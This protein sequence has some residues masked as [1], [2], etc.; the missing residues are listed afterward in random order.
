MT[1]RI[2]IENDP[3]YITEDGVVQV[4]V[5]DGVTDHGALTGLADDD[6][7]QYHNNARGDLRYWPLTTDLATQT[8]LNAAIAN[9][10]YL[11]VANTFVA[12]PN[13]FR[14]PLAS[15]DNLIAYQNSSAVNTSIVTYDGLLGIGLQA[16][17]HIY[18]EPA[19]GAVKDFI[20]IY[21]DVTTFPRNVE[22]DLGQVVG[23]RS[24]LDIEAVSTPNTFDSVNA[25]FF[26]VNITDENLIN[27]YS[28]V[29]V[30]GQVIQFGSHAISNLEGVNFSAYQYGSGLVD[31]MHGIYSE[32]TNYSAGSGTV[33]EAAIL[34]LER[35]FADGPI[36]TKYGIFVG[37]QIN[38]H[39]TTSFALYTNGGETRHKTGAANTVGLGIQRFT[40]QTAHLINVL[41]VDGTTV[42]SYM[43]SSGVWDTVAI[44]SL[45][46]SKITGLVTDLGTLTTA[47]SSE[48]STRASADSTH[49]ALT[50]TAHG[51]IVPSVRSLTIAGT[52][53]D[54]S[55]DRS[56][57]IAYSSLT[58][59]PS[60]F[61]PSTHASSHA[62][63]GSDA[64]TISESQ[65]T[66]LTTDLAAKQS[67]DATLTALAAYNTNGLVTQTGADTF[68]GRT[69]T[70]TLNRID[71]TN[72]NGVSGN[73]VV[74]ISSNYVGQNTI[75]TLGTIVTGVWNGTAIAVANGG[76]G[77]TTAAT[78]LTNLGAAT[79]VAHGR[80][81]LSSTPQYSL[82]GINFTSVGLKTLT[83]NRI[84]YA[85]FFVTTSITLD[86]MAIEI[87]TAGASGKVARL[88]I[89]NAD[90]NWQ[91][92]TQVINA[93]T[94]A[95]DP[96]VVPAIAVASVGITLSPGRYLTAIISDGTPILRKWLGGSMY[97][98][99]IAA[100]GSSSITFQ[101][102][103]GGS[104]TTLPDPG[105]AWT[106][107]SGGGSDMEHVV[108]L[109]VA[110]P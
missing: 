85:P 8:E 79:A 56:W 61:T 23:I 64:I 108:L 70:G 26:R 20:Q 58:S 93:G 96:G 104:G 101:I 97:L 66:N 76:T 17:P 86:Q 42:L 52:A 1:T 35:D 92:T 62:S 106:T 100:L 36:G 29:G 31:V 4:S 107:A 71:I 95:V 84:L 18:P 27:L 65:V 19:Q 75:T 94:V 82:P 109:R 90:V 9:V 68:T 48:A 53:L 2:T 81:K 55:A 12:S 15:T 47:I 57:S 39:I 7:S 41:D 22:L 33:T 32:A 30:Q 25:G 74:D 69:L 59:I 37:S 16:N 28:V 51:G 43:D 72:G 46:E 13:V 54:L 88:A 83:A 80:A 110:T 60:T 50:T 3:V 24:Y 77:A 78:A 14:S 91:P 63:A 38:S 89:Y 34:Y 11:N 10:A 45:P 99:L 40:A 105:T 21:E 103:V 67:L 49:A 44:P 6:H 98:G 5:A 87:T 73:P 102:F